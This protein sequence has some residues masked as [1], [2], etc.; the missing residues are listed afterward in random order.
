MRLWWVDRINLRETR[1]THAGFPG[2]QRPKQLLFHT[3][4]SQLFSCART[5]L[6]SYTEGVLGNLVNKPTNQLGKCTAHSSGTELLLI[7][8]AGTMEIHHKH[9]QKAGKL[10]MMAHLM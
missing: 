7:F 1:S 9:V 2:Q 8:S 5:S 10:Y 4:F 6:K 3:S